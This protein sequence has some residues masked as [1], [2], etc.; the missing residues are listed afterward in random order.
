M[1]LAEETILYSRPVESTPTARL[2]PAQ[3]RAATELIDALGKG[4]V[5]VLRVNSGLGRT[6]ILRHVHTF[7]G[8]AFRSIREFTDALMVRRP[9]AIEQA[10]V[11][12]IEE[13]LANHE[14][15]I[16]DDL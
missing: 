13:A 3:D 7:V 16:L 12:M 9:D 14:T 8:G 2:T 4:N 1:L 10:F 5:F 15:V 11:E 6:T